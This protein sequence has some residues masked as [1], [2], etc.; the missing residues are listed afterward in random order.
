MNVDD[1][2]KPHKRFFKTSKDEQLTMF[3][4]KQINYLMNEKLQ[5]NA[6]KLQDNQLWFKD[7]KF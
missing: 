2:K 7:V 3:I 1:K 5:T 6:N 4:K